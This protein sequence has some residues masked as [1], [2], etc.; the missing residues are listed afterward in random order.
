MDWDRPR[1]NA[2]KWKIEKLKF[3]VFK[4][5]SKSSKNEKW[6][7]T[8]ISGYYIYV[9]QLKLDN[10][11]Y[12]KQHF[13]YLYV[14]N[15]HHQQFVSRYRHHRIQCAIRILRDYGVPVGTA[16]HCGGDADPDQLPIGCPMIRQHWIV[17]N[18]WD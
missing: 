6:V 12:P 13:S 1:E 8:V 7:F 5:H 2:W 15:V 10:F 16:E 11:P 14:L 17:R 4:I 3:I 9:H 18:L